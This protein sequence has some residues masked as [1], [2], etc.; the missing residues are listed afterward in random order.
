MAAYNHAL[1]TGQKLS[2]LK[3]AVVDSRVNTQFIFEDA[4]DQAKINENVHAG[5]NETS[6][7]PGMELKGIEYENNKII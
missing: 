3:G 6:M 7:H 1:L 4:A 2:K 5:F